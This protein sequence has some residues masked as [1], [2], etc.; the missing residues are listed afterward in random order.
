MTCIDSISTNFLSINRVGIIQYTSF[1]YSLRVVKEIQG[2][3]Y[4]DLNK[5]FFEGYF[6]V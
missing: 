3:T 2:L 4:Q 5:R 1:P 6:N